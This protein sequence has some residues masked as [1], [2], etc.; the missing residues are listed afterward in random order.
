MI[1]FKYAPSENTSLREVDR[2]S[3]ILGGNS[4]ARTSGVECQGGGG[5]AGGV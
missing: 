5:R 2:S 4:W 3:T 1:C